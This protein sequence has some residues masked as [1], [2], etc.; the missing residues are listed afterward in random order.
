MDGIESEQDS[1][2]LR[3]GE[4]IVGHEDPIPSPPSV[5]EIPPGQ[6]DCGQEDDQESFRSEPSDE[7]VQD[8]SQEVKERANLLDT[9]DAIS[10]RSSKSQEV[11]NRRLG[12]VGERMLCDWYQPVWGSVWPEHR[13][14]DRL[15]GLTLAP[16]QQS[17]VDSGVHVNQ[18]ALT[19]SQSQQPFN[20]MCKRLIYSINA[21]NKASTILMA[22]A[23]FMVD[24]R[25]EIDQATTTAAQGAFLPIRER[26]L[27]QLDPQF[28]MMGVFDSSSQGLLFLNLSLEDPDL[29]SI[30]GD[31][32]PL[33]MQ[34]KIRGC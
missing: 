3:D 29:E 10:G 28:T 34:T 23:D 22:N 25:P 30:M 8:L 12:F 18:W 32:I 11:S 27:F 21:N 6:G 24:H 4:D 26:D 20:V 17:S 13:V 5:E 1:A 33:E 15:K 9:S 31:D 19:K 2:P 14:F 16:E 7:E